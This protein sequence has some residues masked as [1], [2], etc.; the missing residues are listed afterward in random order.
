MRELL[1]Q[2]LAASERERVQQLAKQKGQDGSRDE[3]RGEPME[4]SGQ[5]DGGEQEQ[6]RLP[7]AHDTRAWDILNNDAKVLQ[8]RWVRVIASK[9]TLI[10]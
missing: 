7:P 4:G 5:E 9:R 10:I 8:K 6:P 3:G 1:L 2:E